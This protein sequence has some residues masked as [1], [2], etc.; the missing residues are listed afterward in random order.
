MKTTYITFK[1]LTDEK[2]IRNVTLPIEHN[3]EEYTYTFLFNGV[4]MR[5][6]VEQQVMNMLDE[7]DKKPMMDK[8]GWV[9]IF[10]YYPAP[11]LEDEFN[12]F[13]EYSRAY[14]NP[15]DRPFRAVVYE[16]SDVL[17]GHNKTNEQKLE[18]VLMGIKI[19]L[20]AATG[21][22]DHISKIMDTIDLKHPADT[23]H[24]PELLE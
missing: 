4:R 17:F 14:I 20:M 24:R 7:M 5:C 15:E 19:S 21:A 23:H 10:D 18:E 12:E 6:T 22:Y 8:N 2:E 16:M 3:F 1:V 13:I 11:T 9:M